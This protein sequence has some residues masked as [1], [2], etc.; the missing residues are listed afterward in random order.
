MSA[1]AD[2]TGMDEAGAG[3]IVTLGDLLL[4]GL[5]ALLS[6]AAVL[7]LAAGGAVRVTLGIALVTLLPGYAI[8]SAVF[9]RRSTAALLPDRVG[10]LERFVLSVGLSLTLT[11]LV[12]IGLA[13][14][15]VGFRLLPLLSV[16]VGVTLLGTTLAAWRRLAARPADRFVLPLGRWRRSLRAHTVEAGF[17]DTLLVALAAVGI[18]ALLAS[19]LVTGPLAA[20]AGLDEPAEATFTEAFLLSSPDGEPVPDAYPSA[21]APGESVSLTVGLGNEEGTRQ[22]YTVLVLAQQVDA[23]TVTDSRQLHRFE[24]TLRPGERWQQAHELRPVFEDGRVRIQYLV[25]RGDP[26]AEPTVENA[27]RELH[28]WVRIAEN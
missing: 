3:W 24:T 1:S 13:L 27:Y 20:T 4:V 6:V 8:V 22:R 25:Y 26:P 17:L 15:A 7:T 12:G 28:V 16:L 14:T 18:V 21:L 11:L 9:P 10:G 23:G 5:A 2:A 19:L